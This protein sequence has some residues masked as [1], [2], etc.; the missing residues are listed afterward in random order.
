MP[1]NTQIDPP[2]PIPE[3]ARPWV[4][5][6]SWILLLVGP[7]AGLLIPML[8]AGTTMKVLTAV[9]G[10]LVSAAAALKGGLGNPIKKVSTT[11]V[12]LGALGLMASAGCKGPY[13]AAWRTLDSVQKARDLTAQQLAAAARA[14]HQEC[15]KAHGAKTAEFASCIKKH[16]ES[17][18]YWRQ[19]ARPATNSAIQVT[20]TAL[21]IAEQAGDGEKKLDWITLLKPAACALMRV[22]KTWG[23]FYPDEGK[24]VLGALQSLEGVTCE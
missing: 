23:H 10:L 14:K 13:D 6:L 20:A 19:I 5:W 15:L 16:R 21:Q 24:A 7:T 2:P 9:L 22:A 4:A 1:N 3:A 17:L 18:D 12:L 11:A 8:T